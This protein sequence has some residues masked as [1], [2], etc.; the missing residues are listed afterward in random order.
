[1]SKSTDSI[2]RAK[3]L[4]FLS[5]SERLSFWNE[6]PLPER[7]H[8]L[9]AMRNTYREQL[10]ALLSA[11][12]LVDSLRFLDPDESTEVLRGVN[13]HKKRKV[14]E[15]LSV[16]I[17]SKVEFLLRFQHDHAAGMMNLDYVQVERTSTF[18]E[19]GNSIRN[20][21]QKTG[22]FP[23]ILVVDSGHLVGELLGHTLALHDSTETVD[24]FIKKV[25]SIQFN[26][27][28][29]DVEALFWKSAHSKI[30][31][32][33]EGN[34]IIGLIFA[35]DILKLINKRQQKELYDF[36]GVNEE[37]DVTDSAFAKV[38]SRYQWLII[39]L[40][41]AFLASAIV[42]LYEETISKYVIL[43]IYMPI[44]AGM[45]GNAGTQTMAITVR[46]LALQKV[47]LSTGLPLIWNEMK[48]GAVNGLISGAIVAAVATIFNGNPMLGAVLAAA[49]IMTLIISGFFGALIPL[50]MQK[51]GKDPATSATI[52]ITTATDVCG[53]LVFLSLARELL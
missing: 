34:S 53:F 48:A 17:K 41:T 20:H 21:E 11:K 1:M 23:A 42:G 46:G 2:S 3:I 18:K 44:V 9:L 39:N 32:L 10:L 25:P 31:V 16:D 12:E 8:V 37:E 7:G 4:R 35:D 22:H 49:M 50:V 15:G 28:Q 30:V 19:V 5:H 26:A 38:K 45:G 27:E 13:A 36:A 47:S 29:G 14:I 43:A 52:F 40:A 33:D 6:I 51:L 24:R